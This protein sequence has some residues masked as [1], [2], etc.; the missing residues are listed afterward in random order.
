MLIILILGESTVTLGQLDTPENRPPVIV[1][2]SPISAE[3]N[4][5]VV[6]NASISDS[7]GNIIWNQ[8]HEFGPVNMRK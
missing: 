6:I 2:T 7:D 4:Q 3:I 8:E 5:T 1:V